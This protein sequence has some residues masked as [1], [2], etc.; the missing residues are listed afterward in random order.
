M[1][2]GREYDPRQV[3]PVPFQEHKG[4]PRALAAQPSDTVFGRSSANHRR[5]F[6]KLRAS[7]GPPYRLRSRGPRLTATTDGW[8]RSKACS[9]GSKPPRADQ[10]ERRNV[11]SSARNRGHRLTFP[12]RPRDGP[13]ATHPKAGRVSPARPPQAPSTCRCS[14]A[15]TAFAANRSVLTRS[16][17]VGA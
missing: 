3:E 13:R 4:V 15:S 10:V 2:N 1:W 12:F 14:D 8:P 9:A 7:P 16:T 6:A 11:P 5:G 17:I